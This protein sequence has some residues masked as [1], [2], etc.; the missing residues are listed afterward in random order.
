M[1]VCKGPAV[2]RGGTVCSRN[3]INGE[4]AVDAL[5][6]ETTG[7]SPRKK[8]N[9]LNTTASSAQAYSTAQLEGT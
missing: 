6:L 5:H 3:H 1:C 7:I 9:S 2:S 4:A 8:N